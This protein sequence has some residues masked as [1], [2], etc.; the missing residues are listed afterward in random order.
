MEIDRKK[1]SAELGIGEDIYGELVGEFI[2]QG[3]AQAGKM[4]EA[5]ESNDLDEIARIAHMVKG[6]SG[7]LRINIIQELARSIESAAK[8]KKDVDTIAGNLAKLEAALAELK[9]G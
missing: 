8:E 3:E 7:N 1:V 9:K 6:T 5:I 2:S 4:K